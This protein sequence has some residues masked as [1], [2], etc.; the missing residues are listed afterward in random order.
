VISLST[1]YTK[2]D[3]LCSGKIFHA[4]FTSNNKCM[5]SSPFQKNYCNSTHVNLD[6]GCT[7]DCSNCKYTSSYPAD[8]CIPGIFPMT[9]GCS[10]SLPPLGKEGI[11][12]TFFSS[13]KCND[14]P[15]GNHGAVYADA[16]CSS[17]SGQSSKSYFN[18]KVY[19]IEFYKQIDCKGTIGKEFEYK[20]DECVKLQHVT[21]F[22]GKFNR[23]GAYAIFSRKQLNF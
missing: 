5:V 12:V 4:A 11:Y 6:S 21:N 2:E 7:S 14:E 9:L 10:T 13:D 19:K 18:G 15:Y 8:K 1:V 3:T 20:M 23:P 16:F 17:G 22:V